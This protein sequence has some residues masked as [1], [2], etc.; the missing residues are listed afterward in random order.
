MEDIHY[1]T[2]FSSAFSQIDQNVHMHGM[3]TDDTAA[4]EE[5]LINVKI[6]QNVSSP[7]IQDFW[8]K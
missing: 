8:G 2:H 7:K 3:K 6:Q 4:D 1:S 5:T